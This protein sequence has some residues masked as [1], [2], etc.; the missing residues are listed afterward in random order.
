MF[1]NI[2]R[3]IAAHSYGPAS[4]TVSDVGGARYGVIE[5]YN[6]YIISSNLV[7]YVILPGAIAPNVSCDLGAGYTRAFRIDK[8]GNSIV[9]I[10]ASPAMVI[11]NIQRTRSEKFILNRNVEVLRIDDLINKCI[12]LGVFK[13]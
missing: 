4:I 8:K 2:S 13:I 1:R 11:G 10:F 12:E 9:C 6:F 7:I 3:F 5:P